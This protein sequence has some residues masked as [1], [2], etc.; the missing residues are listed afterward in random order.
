M[1]DHGDVSAAIDVCL[2]VIPGNAKKI[3]GINTRLSSHNAF[4]RIVRHANRAKLSG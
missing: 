3:D 4:V 2:G 1:F